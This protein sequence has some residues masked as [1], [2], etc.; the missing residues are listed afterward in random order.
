MTRRKLHDTVIAF[1][2]GIGIGAIMTAV[3]FTR[4]YEHRLD[5]TEQEWIHRGAVVDYRGLRE[6]LPTGLLCDDSSLVI[7]A[8]PSRKSEAAGLRAIASKTKSFPKAGGLTVAGWNPDLEITQTLRMWSAALNRGDIKT[9][10][11]FYADQL[12]PYYSS[13]YPVAKT[14]VLADKSRLLA[15]DTLA[16]FSIDEIQP[17]APPCSA[18][19][20]FQETWETRDFDQRLTRH[21]TWNRMHLERRNE[22]W[23]ITG[24]EDLPAPPKGPAHRE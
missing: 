15:S 23:R 16:T 8:D 17:Q 6:C 24:E 22:G 13:K 4:H 19:A 5:D 18:T 1:L 11:A 3:L 10:L 9:H 12:S 20:V 21:Q 7:Y 14:S 2:I